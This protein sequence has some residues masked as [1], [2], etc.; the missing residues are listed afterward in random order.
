MKYNLSCHSSTAI[1]EFVFC[2]P[3][4]IYLLIV[5]SGNTTTMCEIS[6]K[7]T[8]NP[9]NIFTFS[10]TI[11]HLPRHLQEVFKSSSRRLQDVFARPLL[12]MSSRRSRRLLQDVFRT[13]LRHLQEDIL[14]LCLED[15]L[16]DK[17]KLR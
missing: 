2:F 4:S 17:K 7:L 14:K 15:V 8:I 13:S 11:F 9:A 1:S 10:V 5:H 3:V 12:E 16:E 6:S